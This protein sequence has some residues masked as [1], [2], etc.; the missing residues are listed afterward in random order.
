M[1]DKPTV[2]LE[3]WYLIGGQLYGYAHHH[4]RF[5][6]GTLVRTSRVISEPGDEPAKKGD[7]LETLNTFYV[8]GDP[9]KRHEADSESTSRE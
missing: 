7:T 5:E 9:G 2:Q 1:S 6:D 4:P 8:L 3:Q